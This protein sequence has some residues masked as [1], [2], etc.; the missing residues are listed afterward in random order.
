M[1]RKRSTGNKP[2][3]KGKERYKGKKDIIHKRR[4][5]RKP[6]QRGVK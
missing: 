1:Q 5:K 2:D 3:H 4:E 6:K